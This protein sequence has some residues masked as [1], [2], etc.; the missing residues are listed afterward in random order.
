MPTH[1]LFI[2]EGSI[3]SERNWNGAPQAAHYVQGVN[4]IPVYRIWMRSHQ[5]SD[6]TYAI[7]AEPTIPGDV[8]IARA[9]EWNRAYPQAAVPPFG[10]ELD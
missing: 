3:A 7:Y 10:L 5:P 9:R 8:A 2:L 4:Q 1:A 6:T